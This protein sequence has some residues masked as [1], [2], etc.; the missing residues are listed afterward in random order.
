MQRVETLQMYFSC[1]I[2]SWIH[3]ACCYEKRRMEEENRTR[4]FSLINA[5]RLL[6]SVNWSWWVFQALPH[7]GKKDC[8]VSGPA[9][10][11]GEK[12]KWSHQGKTGP[13]EEWGEMEKK[14]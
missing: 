12:D 6:Q 2:I 4:P 8:V 1:L 10:K 11:L 5:S 13:G 3:P 7:D 9:E 14:V